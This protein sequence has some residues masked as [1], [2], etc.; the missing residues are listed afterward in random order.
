MMTSFYYKTIPL[1]ALTLLSFA[2]P[3]NGINSVVQNSTLT[4]GND[5]NEIGIIVEDAAGPRDFDGY[6]EVMKLKT[7]FGRTGLPVY[8]ELHKSKA[9]PTADLW[10]TIIDNLTWTCHTESLINVA[11]PT[12]NGAHHYDSSHDTITVP[13]G[14]YLYI[15]YSAI[16]VTFFAIAISTVFIGLKRRRQNRAN[17]MAVQETSSDDCRQEMLKLKSELVI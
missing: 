13:D 6:P 8:R 11:S 16:A 3:I 12:K 2:A 10:N 15:T 1:L 5:T 9:L 7:I 14:Y 4:E 17:V